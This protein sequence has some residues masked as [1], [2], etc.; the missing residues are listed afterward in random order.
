VIL[1]VVQR[2]EFTW[3]ARAEIVAKYLEVLSR[4]KFAIPE[5]DYLSWEVDL[6]K[7]IERDGDAKFN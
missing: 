4:P 5:Q 6:V 7:Q 1:H 3:V 2:P